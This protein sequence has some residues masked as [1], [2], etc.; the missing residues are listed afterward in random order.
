MRM[1]N[2][3]LINTRS[4]HTFIGNKNPPLF[5]SGK[6]NK[7]V[8]LL[9][10]SREYLLERTAIVDIPAARLCQ[11]AAAGWCVL[12]RP[13]C[14]RTIDVLLQ[15][16]YSRYSWYIIF[17]ITHKFIIEHVDRPWN[18]YWSVDLLCSIG[19]SIRE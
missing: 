14:Q 1:G 6:N 5:T 9:V 2:N 8:V 18:R 17:L 19:K 10:A 12:L 4:R 11:S 16:V 15:V 3:L 13:A 7:R